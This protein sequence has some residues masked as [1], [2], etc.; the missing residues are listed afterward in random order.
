MRR[1]SPAR[2]L[3]AI[4][5][6]LLCICGL[7]SA[8]TVITM[9]EGAVQVDGPQVRLGDVATVEGVSAAQAEKLA[10]LALTSSP[11][12]GRS[13]EIDRDYM[14]AKLHQQG[15]PVRQ[16]VFRGPR[17][18]MATRTSQRIDSDTLEAKLRSSIE[19]HMP[20]EAGD[21]VINI[22]PPPDV[23]ALPTGKT[24]VRF[25]SGGDCRYVGDETFRTTVVVDGRPCKTLY[26]RASVHPFE[27][28][29]VA[30]KEIRRG[31]HIGDSDFTMIR[32]DLAD[33]SGGF[34]TDGAAIRGLVAARSISAGSVISL[35]SVDRPIVIKR[36]KI[37]TAEVSG[38]GFRIT[39]MVKAMDNGRVGDVVR[40]TNVD[41][42]KTLTGEVVDEN[43]V[44]V[45]N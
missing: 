17:S 43:T 34:F 29:A 10:E 19:S 36:G 8:E 14:F 38:R 9:K 23:L 5:G 18:T 7:A 44:R 31:D 37:V 2:R 11:K 39:A 13:K 4:L 6:F 25:E 30:V 35:R 24:G 12:P 1:A 16:T 15:Y 40:L 28:V 27:H 3:S 32:K 45:A 41:S 20:W 21:T 33:L 26:L 42:R 22:Q